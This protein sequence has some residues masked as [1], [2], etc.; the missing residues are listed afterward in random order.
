M[1]T[2]DTDKEKRIPIPYTLISIFIIL[3][4]IIF[5]A[6]Y[7][8]NKKQEIAIKSAVHQ[9]LNA[10]SNL[11][12]DQITR[13]RNERLQLANV[14]KN[15]D[16]TISII[17]DFLSN[18]N[19]QSMTLV[20]NYLATIKDTYDFNSCFLLDAK[21]SVKLSIYDSHNTI[22]EKTTKLLKE[23][24]DKDQVIMTDIHRHEKSGTIQIDIIIPFKHNYKPIGWLI[25]GIDPYKILFPVIQ[26][27]PTDSKTGEFLLVTKDND[28]VLYLN[29]LRH[30][31]DTALQ[32][33]I[34]LTNDNMPAV[35]AVKGVKGIVEGIDYRGMPVVASLKPVLDSPW[36]LV[37]KIDKEEAYAWI[38][39]RSTIIML[40][41]ILL[42]IL[43]SLSVGL[44]WRHQRVQFYKN[45]YQTE[46]MH[47]SLL[48]KYEH[49]T[50][51]ANDIIFIIDEKNNIIE[52]NENALKTY[53]YSIDELTSMNER[54]IRAPEAANLINE[55]YK[56]VIKHDG[57]VFE[58][59]HKKKNGDIFPVEESSR[60]L[61][62]EGKRFFVAIC[63]DITERKKSEAK[64]KETLQ[65][66]RNLEDI[67]N[68]SPAVAFL[69]RN[70]EGLPLEFISTNISIY[71]YKASYLLT[72]N[73]PFTTLI[74]PEDIPKFL[75]KLKDIYIEKIPDVDIQHRIIT[76]SGDIRWEETRIWGF[77]DSQGNI[78]HYQGVMLDITEQKKL[79]DQLIQAQK[80]EAVGHLAGGVA[81]DFNNILTAIVGYSYMLKMNL[82]DKTSESYINQILASAERATNLTQSLLAFSRKQIMNIVP[83]N[84]NTLIHDLRKLLSRLITEDIELEIFTPHERLMVMADRTQ[85]EQILINL[86]SN[87]KDA[88]PDGG[89]LLIET[90]II[91]IDQEYIKSHGY[92]KEGRY[93]L[94]SVTD[95]GHGIDEK[96]INRIFEPFFTTKEVGKGTG[97]GLSNVYGIVKQHN[98]YI[99]VYSEVGKGTTFKIYLPITEA[100]EILTL[101]EEP[102]I[103]LAGTET[104]LIAEDDKTVRNLYSKTLQIYGYKIIEASDGDEAISRFMEN[105][106]SIQLLIL[107]VIMPKKN[108]KEVHDE[109]KAIKPDIKALFLSGYTENIIHKKGILDISYNFLRKPTS[110]KEL[111]RK[112]REILDKKE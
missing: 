71:G 23:A 25:L 40:L 94:L 35:M 86:V 109:I 73:T 4:V 80:M 45:Q 83:I 54:D 9:E 65:E 11:K 104:I 53:G 99:N 66:L 112:I 61:D 33:R 22:S 15:S 3:S 14:M 88:M 96:I 105:K 13:W 48:R 60:A 1:N 16:F 56:D 110:P 6:S 100:E 32:L 75:D 93:A 102:S 92:G 97:L 41:S 34:P 62:I 84:I 70:T 95:T 57:F 26:L 81:H 5:T 76:S 79:H 7:F 30:K 89:L 90:D 24:M 50:Q 18:P 12:L 39:E 42:I 31:K 52:A 44:I 55:H 8:Y 20:T 37:T 29:E 68:K 10:I 69:C 43:S 111:L 49:I 107:D 74:Y 38:S 2:S 59:F 82:D 46:K 21:G 27:L 87:A 58:T 85:L 17:R 106:D 47:S 108:G 98:G 101:K 67:I 28:D 19:N 63:R 91:N 64:L 72:D 51:H 36:F 103:S 78:T 77:Y